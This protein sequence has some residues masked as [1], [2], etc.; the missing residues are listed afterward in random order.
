[1]V[2]SKKTIINCLDVRGG[3]T[4]SREGPTFYRG[5]RIAHSLKQP[6]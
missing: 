6:I 5:G 1:M 2:K 3:P 4:F